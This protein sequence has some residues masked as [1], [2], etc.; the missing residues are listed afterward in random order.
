MCWNIYLAFQKHNKN[1]ICL[2]FCFPVCFNA[3]LISFSPSFCLPLLLSLFLGCFLVS[4]FGPLAACVFG[5]A[6]S[7]MVVVVVVAAP[8][9]KGKESDASNIWRMETQPQGGTD[10]LQAWL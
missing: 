4:M 3:F 7:V 6:E 8:R 9:S 2:L 1:W 10:L 5:I